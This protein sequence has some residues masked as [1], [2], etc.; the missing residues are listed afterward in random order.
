[1]FR[2]DFGVKGWLILIALIV[3]GVVVAY[4]SGRLLERSARAHDV[5]AAEVKYAGAHAEA[6]SLQSVNRLLTANVWT[7]RASVALDERNFGVAND[8][9]AKVVASL[10]QIAPEAAEFDRSAVVALRDAAKSMNISVAT[11]L[12]PQR[13][14]VLKLAADLTALAESAGR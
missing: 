5:A 1:M 6:V 13:A 10:D 7:Y 11:D 12:E 3:I 9:M 8:A 4:F 2:R 14:R